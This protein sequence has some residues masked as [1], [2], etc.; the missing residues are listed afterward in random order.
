[1]PAVRNISATFGIPIVEA[2]SPPLP[3]AA[4]E[5]PPE[6]EEE[7]EEEEEEEEDKE[8]CGLQ[9][10]PGGPPPSRSDQSLPHKIHFDE[11]AQPSPQPAFSEEVPSRT[12]TRES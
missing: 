2:Q 10:P 1:M 4:E 8:A 7:T 12:R 9:T 11:S 3:F 5:E 6:E